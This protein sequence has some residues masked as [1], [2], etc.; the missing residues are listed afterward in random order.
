M[1]LSKDIKACR[2]PYQYHVVFDV[3][4]PRTEQEMC[5]WKAGTYL[6]KRTPLI[7]TSH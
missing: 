1:Q 2:L 3:A 5:P 6:L 4:Y 7:T